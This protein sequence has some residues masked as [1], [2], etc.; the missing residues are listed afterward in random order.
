MGRYPALLDLRVPARLH[1]AETGDHPL[2]ASRGAGA[3]RTTYTITGSIAGLGWWP[4]VTLCKTFTYR[5]T[6]QEGEDCRPD[7]GTLVNAAMSQ[8]DGDFECDIKLLAGTRLVVTRWRTDGRG[9]R[10]RSF[11]LTH[12]PSLADV[13][14]TTW[15]YS[16]ES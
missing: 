10:S 9:H 4:R 5:W 6:R 7:L 13:T 3:V 8:E 11:P 14:S 12:F 1:A 15:P 16:E 2:R